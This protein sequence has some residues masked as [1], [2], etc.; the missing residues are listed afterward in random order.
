MATPKK[1]YPYRELPRVEMV[2]ANLVENFGYGRREAKE[3]AL[4]V[5]AN[6]DRHLALMQSTMKRLANQTVVNP[7]QTSFWRDNG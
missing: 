5:C 4:E 2:K 1:E 6:L 3:L 7:T